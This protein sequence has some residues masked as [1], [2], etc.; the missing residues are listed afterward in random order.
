MRNNKKHFSTLFLR[1]LMLAVTTF[2]TFNYITTLHAV[3]AAPPVGAKFAQLK[4]DVY[5]KQIVG[6][7]WIKATGSMTLSDGD[8]VR[9]GPKSSVIIKSAGGMTLKIMPM[10]VV[11]VSFDKPS[12][13][14]KLDSG[15]VY[16]R[17]NTGGA[18]K[19]K[20]WNDSFKITTP[21][22]TSG[23]R[24]TF[25]GISTGGDE[26]DVD[27]FD[28]SVEVRSNAALD[29]EGVIVNPNMRTRAEAGKAPETPMPIPEEEK[30]N[31]KNEFSDDEYNLSR[32]AINVQ[33]KPA[34]SG[35]VEISVNVT[36]GNK[37]LEK[38]VSVQLEINGD[39]T[40]ENGEKTVVI[41]TDVKGKA[42]VIALYKSKFGINAAVVK[43]SDN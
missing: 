38:P 3:A 41:A 32:F 40:F 39:A 2:F 22:A 11:T 15:K 5:V 36:A 24:G 18:N 6:K 43:D 21:C 28:G 7:D 13:P 30:Q 35:K 19:L 10:S 9:T 27:V 37:E 26:T 4:G 1:I 42:I 33:I 23:V 29:R 16:L 31:L 12:E 14:T 17:E 8:Q 25:T 34:G 20:P